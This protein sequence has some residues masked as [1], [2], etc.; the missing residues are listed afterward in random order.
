[1]R[2][3]FILL[4]LFC[5]P[6]SFAAAT[7]DAQSLFAAAR[8]GRIEEV[9]RLIAA[10]VPVDATDKYGTS[11]MMMA[12]SSGR[13]EVV[14]F[15]LEKGADAS[16]KENF[17]GTTALGWMGFS[18]TVDEV[19]ER[20]I[21][22][23]LLEHGAEDRDQVLGIAIQ[24]GDLELLRA[25]V[26]SGPI[27]E[28]TL[29]RYTAGARNMD[30]ALKEMLARAQT[31]PDPPP[32]TYT[33]ADLARFA[34][35]Y[36]GFASGSVVDVTIADER[37]LMTIGD[38]EPQ[39]LEVTGEQAFRAAGGATASFFGRAGTVEG[40][41]LAQTGAQ[42][43]AL[44][45]S[46]AEPAGAAAFSGAAEATPVGGEATVNWPS[47][48]GPGA[49]GVGDGAETPVRWTIESGDGVLWSAEIPGLG[50]SS[51]VVWGQT[52][53]LTTAVAAGAEQK[54]RTGL[55]GAGDP[56]DESV[57]H[58]WLVLAFD[59]RTGEKLWES[60]VGRAVPITKRHFKATQANSTPATDGEHLVVIFPTAGLAC[61][62][63]DGEIHWKKELGG[64]NAGAFTDPGVEWGFASSPFLYGSL[65][66]QQ[67]DV[68]GGQYLAAWDLESGREVWRTE[69]SV[70]PSW[71]TPNVLPGADG[72]ELVV[73]GSTIYGYDPATG[74]E[75]W[76]LGP[77]SELVI[78]TPVIGHGMAFVSAGYPPVKPIY[79][80]E[81][82]LRGEYEV[83]PGAVEEGL[84][85]S[86]GIGGAYMPTPL[87]YRGLLYVVHHNGRLV[88]Y[89]ARSG[90]A[91]YKERFSKG[92]TFTGSPIAVNG[93][94]YAG[95]EEGYLYV[96]RAGPEYEELGVNDTGEPLM[97]TPAV[98]DGVLFLR[99]PSRLIAVGTSPT[100]VPA[101]VPG[102]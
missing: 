12:A 88:T 94:I 17:Y 21:A 99:T 60:E 76:R 58:R 69:R 36:E 61:L 95:T 81:S 14:R 79:A 53:F 43:D 31:R 10:G 11:A 48:R 29:A 86:H 82:G 51:P 13:P 23:L 41:Q 44:R 57:E 68:H 91:I 38:G 98:S 59:K 18:G 4:A 71:A 20:E 67:V 30:A 1:M 66:I 97:A 15:L 80:L 90:A 62:G 54:I 8:A 56:V 6:L 96:L 63:L 40:I 9:R 50:N 83:E 39:A 72:D 52:V 78:A 93:K 27:A 100:E 45:R 26:E 73:N 74:K 75:L 64:L 2:R 5:L 55:T 49:S 25:A 46:V 32:P 34:G 16:R 70:A 7:D 87:L 37:L 24:N 84:A 22:M 89:D 28:S 77:N 42:P 101:E 47:F 33:A 35:R 102:S 65:V 19:I 85:W 3:L 92:G